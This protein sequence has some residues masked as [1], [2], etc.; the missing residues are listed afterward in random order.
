M[1]QPL[2]HWRSTARVPEMD[3]SIYEKNHKF[4]F[5]NLLSNVNDS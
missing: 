3:A 5:T 4:I 1:S 2:N